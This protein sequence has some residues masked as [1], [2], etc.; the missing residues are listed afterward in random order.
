V[1]N[2]AVS[3]LLRG[4]QL[5]QA[6]LLTRCGVLM[7]DVLLGRSVEQLDCLGV[8]G[9]G[10]CPGCSANLPER[11]TERT[12]VRAVLNGPGTTLTQALSG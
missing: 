11:C 3:L 7:Y 10:L 1:W 8:G 6:A 4:N 2:T 9:G 12:A 5:R